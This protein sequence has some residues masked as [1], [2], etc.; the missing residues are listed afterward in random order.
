MTGKEYE[1]QVR[2]RRALLKSL[3]RIEEVTPVEVETAGRLAVAGDH[4]E[5]VL[6]EYLGHA[7]GVE[8]RI[9]EMW[10]P[11]RGRRPSEIGILSDHEGDAARLN[12][13]DHRDKCEYESK[14][15]DKHRAT[16]NRGLR[17]HTS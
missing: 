16:P 5:A 8:D 10:E 12:R 9:V 1:H 2:S 11:D 4:L 13:T 6:G 7:V 3:E 15:A 14:E 17:E